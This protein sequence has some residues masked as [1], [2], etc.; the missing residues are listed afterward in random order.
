MNVEIINPSAWH[1]LRVA[2]QQ[3]SRN[4]FDA[5]PPAAAA[6]KRR[7]RAE[8]EKQG[9][10]IVM[11]SSRGTVSEGGALRSVVRE[12]PTPF[13]KTMGYETLAEFCT[14]LGE[15]DL[16]EEQKAIPVA[17]RGQRVVDEW[18]VTKQ[19]SSIA[20]GAKTNLP[21]DEAKRYLIESDD[22][23][24]ITLQVQNQSTTRT[25]R[26]RNKTEA[27]DVHVAFVPPLQVAIVTAGKSVGAIVELLST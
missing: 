1:Q 14:E 12:V 4:V 2:I 8:L 18:T 13:Y 21:M 9:A 5:A 24:A 11:V 15:R 16:R 7:S 17:P 20:P 10:D 22:P 3:R 6:P 27:G 26:L 23:E 19:F 25:L